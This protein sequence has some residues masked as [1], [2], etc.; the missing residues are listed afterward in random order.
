MTIVPF[1]CSLEA[2]YEAIEEEFQKVE[3]N[4]NAA[5]KHFVY[6]GIRY[7]RCDKCHKL[8]KTDNCI[9]Y[10]GENERMFCGGCRNCYGQ[11]VQA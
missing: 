11:G 6:M 8:V 3:S 7:V 9:Y 1:D 4:P 10:G 2:F 5:C